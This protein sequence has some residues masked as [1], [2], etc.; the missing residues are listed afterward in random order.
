MTEIGFRIGE[1]ELDELLGY[2]SMVAGETRNTESFQNSV[3]D[4]ELSE[5][6]D[7]TGDYEVIGFDNF[8]TLYSMVYES[9][10]RYE[11]DE[12]EKMVYETD[13][14]TRENRK[15]VESV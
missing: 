9:E 15:K 5:I 14:V 1:D 13:E 3:L 4:G 12:L 10:P 6:E 8:T 7:V 11:L 2:A